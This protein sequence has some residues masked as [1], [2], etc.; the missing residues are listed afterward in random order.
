MAIPNRPLPVWLIVL[1][2][3][4]VILGIFWLIGIQVRVG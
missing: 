2:A 4:L 3:I 1:I